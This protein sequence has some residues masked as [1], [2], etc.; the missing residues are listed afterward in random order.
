MTTVVFLGGGRITSAMLAGL[1]LGKAKHR[2]MVHDRNPGK[3]W[4]LKKRYRVEVE[5]DLDR[6]VEQ[7]DV[8][9]VAVRPGSV[10][11]LLGAVEQAI[12]KLKRPFFRQTFAV[13]L[14]AGVP[15][16]LL[17]ELVG[18]PIQ[19]ARAMPSPVCRLSLIHI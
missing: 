11:K 6:A 19:W 17:S 15:L 1:R 13:S 5:P 8:L 7:A 2:L 14:A 16:R 9:I 4:D 12:E 18:P 3:L 10:G